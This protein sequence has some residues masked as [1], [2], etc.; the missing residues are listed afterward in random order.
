MWATKESA[1]LYS[2]AIQWIA[3]QSEFA[4]GVRLQTF[5]EPFLSHEFL[6]GAAWLSQQDQ[7]RFVELVTNG[8]RLL[9]E[10][11]RFA[12]EAAPDKITLWITYHP[13]ECDA[14]ALLANALHAK[15]LGA[16]VIVNLLLFPQTLPTIL[17]M[18]D[19]C[20]HEGLKYHVDL[21][22]LH[23]DIPVVHKHPDTVAE[24][25]QWT[26]VLAVHLAASITSFDQPCCAGHTFVRILEDGS[27]VP[28]APLGQHA[29]HPIRFGHV[30][31]PSFQL[32]GKLYKTPMP[33]THRGECRCKEE[34]LNFAVLQET[35]VRHRSLGLVEPRNPGTGANIAQPIVALGSA[36]LRLKGAL[37]R[38]QRKA[39]SQPKPWNMEGKGS[40]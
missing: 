29:H 6:K 26:D 34:F 24:L 17:L 30:L 25:Y 15:A 37:I 28:C 23:R 13:T 27:V 3:D 22:Y 7:I 35:Y 19:R 4:K 40:P 32:A 38:Q 39:H 9:Q 33:C 16:F 36:G 18:R 5:G 1:S 21:G 12:S 31:D 14:D 11:E 10:Y 2:R 20:L 8:S